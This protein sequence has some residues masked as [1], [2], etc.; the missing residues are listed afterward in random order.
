MNRYMRPWD[1]SDPAVTQALWELEDVALLRREQGQDVAPLEV[2][3]ALPR[4]RR[5]RRDA[6]AR[7]DPWREADDEVLGLTAAELRK[8]DATERGLLRAMNDWLDDEVAGLKAAIARK[9]T[10]YAKR[11]WRFDPS[12]LPE[13]RMIERLEKLRAAVGAALRHGLAHGSKLVTLAHVVKHEAGT[14]NM[15][16][17]EA[18]AYAFLNRTGGVVRHPSASVISGYQR[19]DVLWPT[20]DATPKLTYLEAFIDCLKAAQK[21]LDDRAPTAND[22][23]KGATHWVSPI[24]LARYDAKAHGSRRYKRTVDGAVDR[25]FPLW[26]RA[27]ADPE[28]PTMQQARQLGARF[29]ELTVKGVPREQFLFYVDVR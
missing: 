27:P 11:N 21:R 24:G 19:L 15:S 16:A 1:A 20:L 12:T 29:D 7:R 17:K 8:F 22:P 9:K 3:A 2:D 13:T 14:S 28:V 6:D 18:V 5:P 23:T 10:R 26:A 4:R 25:A